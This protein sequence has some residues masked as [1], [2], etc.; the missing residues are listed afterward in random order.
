MCINT[1]RHFHRPHG[2]DWVREELIHKLVFREGRT[3]RTQ[4]ACL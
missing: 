4:L 2:L 3:N 1:G